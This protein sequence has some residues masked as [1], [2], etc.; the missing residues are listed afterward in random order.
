MAQRNGLGF[1]AEKDIALYERDEL[2]SGT[3]NPYRVYSPYLRA[4]SKT[5]K[6][7]PSS[8]VR[9]LARQPKL[10]SMPLPDLKHWD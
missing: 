10:Q 5:P 9:K 7:S 6:P 2:L 8:R 4:W 3:G 1:H